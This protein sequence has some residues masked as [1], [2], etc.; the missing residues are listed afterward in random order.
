MRKDTSTPDAVD[1]AAL[2]KVR[3]L[4]VSGTARAIRVAA[5]LSLAEMGASI[6][7][8]ASTVLR[9]ERG[10]RM[11]HGERAIRYLELLERISGDA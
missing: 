9:W 5:D 1:P 7:A 8:T 4:A 6:P 11:P 10:Q 3:R 2:A